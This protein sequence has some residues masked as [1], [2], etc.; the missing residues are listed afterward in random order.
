MRFLL[1]FLG[2]FT[3]LAWLLWIMAG[4]TPASPTLET[5]SPEFGSE[6]VLDTSEIPQ[7]PVRGEIQ[8]LEKNL[9]LLSFIAQVAPLLGLLGT[10]L[11]M[12]D[13]FIGLQGSG[14]SNVDVSALSSGI[15]KALLTTAAGLMVAVPTLCPR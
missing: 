10:V 11:G 14:L 2:L 3:P 12:V 9:A 5:D 13:L 4:D 15:W 1:T 6:P 7:L 8:R